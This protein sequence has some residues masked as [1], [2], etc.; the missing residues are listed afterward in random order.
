MIG[1]L[2]S[3]SHA[4][5]PTLLSQFTTPS[6]PP[7]ELTIETGRARFEGDVYTGALVTFRSASPESA[8]QEVL[9][10]PELQDEWHPKELGTEKVERIVATNFYQRTAISVLGF[11]IRRQL[12]AQVRWIEATRTRLRTCW[13]AGDPAA[14][15]LRDWDNGTPWQRHGYGS[16]TITNLPEGG[17]S[18]AYQVW[19]DTNG[20]PS[21]LISWGVTRTLPTLLNGFEARAAE[22]HARA[23]ATPP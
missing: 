15:D 13:T 1:I 20:V 2:T 7:S 4:C 18:V 5:E 12:I 21:G 9:S 11:T 6:A 16:W 19:V 14:Y 10:H 17:A 3:L 8:W 22:L 23:P